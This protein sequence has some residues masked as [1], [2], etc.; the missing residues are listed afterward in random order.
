VLNNSDKFEVFEHSHRVTKGNDLKRLLLLNSNSSN[1]WISR[2]V[3]YTATMVIGSIA[4]YI[5]GLGERQPE[6]ILMLIL[7]RSLS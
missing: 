7:S 6:N 3:E 5:L 1:H 2:R 4:G